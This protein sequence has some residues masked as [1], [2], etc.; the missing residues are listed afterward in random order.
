MGDEGERVSMRFGRVKDR[1][2]NLPASQSLPFPVRISL[3]G[4][5]G[6]CEI[7]AVVFSAYSWRARK[8]LNILQLLMK[9]QWLGDEESNLDSRSQ[10]PA[11]Y[12]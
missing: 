3:K 2:R 6:L 4:L 1:Q 5:F 8:L 9:G 12:H 7:C 10:S 11:S